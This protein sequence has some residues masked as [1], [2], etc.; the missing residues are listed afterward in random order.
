MGFRRAAFDEFTDASFN[1]STQKERDPEFAKLLEDAEAQAAPKRGRKSNAAGRRRK[2]EKEEDAELLNDEQKDGDDEGDA[3]FVFT[4]SPT[5]A[6][7]QV[8]SGW[9]PGLSSR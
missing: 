2:S 3:P 6:F 9:L 7:R 8:F 1:W 5:C 4:E